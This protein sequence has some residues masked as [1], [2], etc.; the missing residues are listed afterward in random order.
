MSG[1]PARL[2]ALL[3]L[4]C[5]MLLT[6]ACSRLPEP[7]RPAVST[8]REVVV[9]YFDA[10]RDGREAAARSLESPERRERMEAV[11]GEDIYRGLRDLR[12]EG[13]GVT[14]GFLISREAY[15]DYPEQQQFVVRF[16][17]VRDVPV[18]DAGEQMRFVYVGRETS[19]TPWVVLEVGS[20]P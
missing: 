15:G 18:A 8:P 7:D 4:A 20:G 16:V 10:L 3:A 6:A 13:P 14:G 2:P 12:V 11:A 1:R 5:A 17:S 19:S 9:A